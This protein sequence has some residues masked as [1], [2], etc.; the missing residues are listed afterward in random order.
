[1]II[2]F[3]GKKNYCCSKSK[4]IANKILEIITK[5]DYDHQNNNIIIIRIFKCMYAILILLF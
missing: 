3:K 1:M 4:I 2:I 5:Y